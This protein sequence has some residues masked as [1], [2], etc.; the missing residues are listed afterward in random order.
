MPL[1]EERPSPDPQAI[2]PDAESRVDTELGQRALEVLERLEAEYPP[3]YCF[4]DADTPFQL[5]VAV[6][7]SAQCTDE[8]VNQVIEELFHHYPT[9]E[10]LAA[11]EREHVEELVY[12]T[13][14]YRSKAKY[15]QGTAQALVEEHDGEVPD[16]AAELTELPGVARK[17]ATAVLWYAYGK[18]EGVTVDTH[19]LR[20]T[21]RLGLEESGNRNRVERAWMELTPQERWSWVPYL[22]IN[23]GRAVCDAKKPDC[24]ACVLHDLCPSAG[25]FD[26]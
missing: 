16:T 18:V 5:L 14:F 25:T 4:L 7:L 12:S 19:V 6:I 17:T 22:L 3:M 23:H 13:G 2:H 8:M 24:G 15:I 9:A 26:A 21:E 20:L 11:A 10:A 1:A